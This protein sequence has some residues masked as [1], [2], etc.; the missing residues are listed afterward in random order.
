MMS[1]CAALEVD[2]VYRQQM[3]H[4]PVIEIKAKYVHKTV[5]TNKYVYA[6]RCTY[7]DAHSE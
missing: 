3:A 4:K 1:M 5:D 7:D 2:V 6:D